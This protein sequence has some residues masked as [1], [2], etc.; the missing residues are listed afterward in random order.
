VP[1]DPDAARPGALDG[2]RLALTTLTV[3]PVRGP[4]RLDRA[5]A[6]AA[7]LLAPVVGV[8]LALPLAGVLLGAERLTQGPPLLA[9]VL[10]VALHALATRGLHLDGLAD[11]ADGLG[12][13]GSPERARAVMK[14]PDV[15]ALGAAAL[16]LVPAV[17]VAALLACTLAGRGGLAVVLSVVT[18]RVAVTA[19]CTAGVPAAAPEGLGALVAGTVPRGS[20]TAG[21]R[22]HRRGRDAARRR[23]GPAAPA[24]GGGGRR[25]SARR[26]A[27]ARAR[28]AA[29]RRD[30]RGR[31]RR[32]GRG[33]D[34]GSAR[35]PVG[36]AL[37]AAT[38]S[39][40]CRA[41]CTGVRTSMS[42]TCAAAEAYS[43]SRCSASTRSAATG[44]SATRTRPACRAE[45]RASVGGDARSQTT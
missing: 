16:V 10:V 23:G 45:R 25:R 26:P 35:R 34:R 12:S 28:R 6:G 32:A 36:Q 29:R 30:H 37:R 38:A 5:T 17:Q 7:M 18:A 2:L 11:L 9:C 4:A 15:G 13:Y 21:G 27:A 41:A 31:P 8:L 20:R 1:D 42:R 3:L 14:A 39:T 24:A 19:A 33:D 40:T 44:S 43:R 22:P